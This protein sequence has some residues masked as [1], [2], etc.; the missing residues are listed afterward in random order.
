MISK[1]ELI[2]LIETETNSSQQLASKLSLMGLGDFTGGPYEE[3]YWHY[4][5][6]NSMNEP[7][8]ELLHLMIQNWIDDPD[9]NDKLEISNKRLFEL[10]QNYYNMY[11][12]W[13]TV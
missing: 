2:K 7:E 8:L 3:W 1:Q 6:L 12:V 10:K 4:K 5:A 11:G 13:L 9:Y